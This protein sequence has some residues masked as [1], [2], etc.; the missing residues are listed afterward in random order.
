MG[1]RSWSGPTGTRLTTIAPTQ[2]GIGFDRTPSGSNAIGQYAPAVARCFAAIECLPERYLLW[3]HRLGWSHRTRSGLTV[4]EELVTRYSLGVAQVQAMRAAWRSL[5]PLI[6]PERFA[7]VDA[8]LAIQNKE[9]RWWRDASIAY[10][11][12]K[13][14]RPLPPGVA[15]PAEDLEHYKSRSF[16][17]APGH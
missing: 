15:P 10:F 13:S 14:G 8:F 2:S 7:E 16:P 12:S 6:D 9:A 4:W 5:R 11:Q 1:R 3:F 17:Y